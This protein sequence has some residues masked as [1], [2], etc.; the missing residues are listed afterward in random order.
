MLGFIKG[1]DVCYQFFNIRH[2]LL[3]KGASITPNLEQISMIEKL[4]EKKSNESGRTHKKEF[5]KALTRNSIEK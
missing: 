2:T 4:K 3:A 5:Y 1:L